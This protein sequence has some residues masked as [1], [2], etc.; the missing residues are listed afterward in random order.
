MKVTSNSWQTD[1]RMIYRSAISKKDSA[2]AGIEAKETDFLSRNT[3]SVTGLSPQDTGSGLQM[4]SSAPDDSV[5]QLAAELARSETQLDVRQVMSKAMKALTNLKMSSCMCE[6]KEAK[7]I[8]QMIRRMEKLI[9]RIQKKIKLLG[10]EE[11][12]ENRQKRAE[13][14]KQFETAE[15]IRDDLRGRRRKRHRDEREYARK[16]LIEDSRTESNEMI[17]SMMQSMGFSETGGMD[18]SAVLGDMGSIDITV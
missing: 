2:K 1:A 3:D 9:K 6:G 5:G 10:K 4:K 8:A 7:K 17:D 15:Q 14:Q 12:L 13:K 16:E 18:L 11:Q